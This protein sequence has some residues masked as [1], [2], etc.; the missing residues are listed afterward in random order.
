MIIII[1]R[2]LA[3]GIPTL[4]LTLPPF[5]SADFT[6]S[7]L[8]ITCLAVMVYSVSAVSRLWRNDMSRKKRLKRETNQLS[9]QSA[10]APNPNVPH[11]P[12]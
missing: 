1:G 9:L 8:F 2:L 6:D 12:L 3:S 5:P 10:A 7:I 4:L 11:P